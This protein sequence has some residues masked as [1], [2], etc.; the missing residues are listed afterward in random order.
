MSFITVARPTSEA[1]THTTD[2]PPPRPWSPSA[3]ATAAPTPDGVV[4]SGAGFIPWV[5]RPV[6]NPGRTSSSRTPEPCR[7]S[8]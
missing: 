1:G 2:L 4:A 5:I 8:A 7:E 6:T 3:L